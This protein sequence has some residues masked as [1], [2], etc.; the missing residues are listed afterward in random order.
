MTA[1]VWSKRIASA[2]VALIVALQIGHLWLGRST[3]SLTDQSGITNA[4]YI[5]VTLA[6][7][8]LYAAV[9]WA[10]VTRQPR[11]TIGWLLLALPL[12]TAIA[13]FVG[14]YATEALAVDPGSLPFARL[15]AW[16]DRWTIVV[17]LTSFIPLFLLFPNGRLPSRRWRPALWLT[18]LG[19]AITVVSFALT[20]GRMTGAFADLTTVRVINPFGSTPSTPPCMSARSSEVCF[21]PRR[22][23]SQGSRSSCD[24]GGH[25]RMSAS[26]SGGSGS[27][28]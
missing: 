14:D 26:R 4:I 2:I 22:R 27:S 5:G 6:F 1:S 13:L 7:S 12:L 21:A 8:A 23:S 16:I 11:N 10:I 18:I 15:A 9:G 17:L 19:P 20:P 24:T 25:R 3:G 28:G